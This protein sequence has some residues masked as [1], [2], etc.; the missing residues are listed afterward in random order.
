MNNIFAEENGA[1][2][3]DCTDAVWAT[4][5]IHRDYQEAGLHIND[6]DFLIENNTHIIMVEYKNACL[7]EA[8]APDVFNPMADKKIL[9][10]TRKFYDSLH[11]L[12]LLDKQKPVQ[13][14]YILEYPKGDS[15]TR[16]RLRNKLKAEL[17]F[18]LQELVGNGNKLIDKIDVVSI[19]EWNAD[20]VYGKYPIKPT[21]RVICS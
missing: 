8:S 3:I 11:Y 14:V 16:R 2:C 10:V 12:R 20:G 6:V 19:K 4:D 21:V 13:Y 15:T 18:A 1:Y 17:P 7:A 9:T 5:R